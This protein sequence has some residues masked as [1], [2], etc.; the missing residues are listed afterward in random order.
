MIPVTQTRLMPPCDEHGK[1][2]SPPGN[3]WSA[4]IASIL[5]LPIEAVPDEATHWKP[6]MT[7]RQS[8]RPFHREMH[9]F[10]GAR[11]FLL[12][13]LPRSNLI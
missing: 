4:C 1:P 7:H 12:L 10:C 11:G 3:C 6:G 2:Q 8:W 13:E 5:E 9:E